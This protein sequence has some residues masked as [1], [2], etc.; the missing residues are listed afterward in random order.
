MNDEHRPPDFEGL[1]PPLEATV[2]AALAGPIPEDAIERVKARARQLAATAISPSRTSGSYHRG[3]KASRSIIAGLTAVAALLAVVI[4]VYSLLNHSG[5]R[6]FAQM[7]EKVKASSSVR[8]TTATRF[9]KQPEINGV[10]YLEGNRM[11]MEQFDGTLI[12][13]AD[14]DR[15]LGL[16]LDMHGKTVQLIEIDADAARRFANPIDQLRR[17]KSDD[18]EQIGE[19][20]LKG[21]RTR[22]YRLRKADLFGITGAEMLVWVDVESGLPA[23]IV[24]RDSDPKAGMEFRFD[25]F[26]WNE[27]LN[28][29][30]FS[31]GMP[32]GF[33]TGVV[34]STPRPKK[35]TQANATPPNNPNYLADGVLSRDHVPARIVWNPRGTTITALTQDPESV[36]PQERRPHELRQ[37]DV[38]TG[39]LR[40]SETVLGAGW[41]AGTADGKTL[42]TVIGYEVQ[43]RDAA[44]GKIT[45]KWATDERLSPLAFSPDGKTLAAGITEWGRYGGRG[46]K[47][48]GGV[49]F[50]DVERACLVRSISDDKPV[51]FVRYSVDGKYLAT[52]SNEGPEKS[53]DVAT[54]KLTRIFPGRHRADFS[55]DGET[56]ACQSAASSADKTIGKVDLY[57][58]RDGSLVKS[59][60]SEKG[61][62][63]SWLLCVTFSPDGHLL[64]ASDWN[65]TVTL[66]DV[67][68][69][70]C[71]QTITDHQAGVLAVVFAPDGAAL[72]TGSEDNTLR[73]RKLPAELRPN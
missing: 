39:K 47:E 60:A 10:M 61:A 16:L 17:A 57:K 30:L 31:L 67:A 25:E 2:K 63:A 43:L 41:L 73:L 14:F 19:E 11:R 37:W 66:W 42:A 45:R 65:G 38:A 24:I 28:A 32:D 6:A 51:T 29:Q 44:S 1:E 35:A 49:Q 4:G 13:V 56:I 8:F 27:P 70:E 20:I 59:F 22:V 18:A 58:L 50:W 23:K 3:W 62:S 55:P 69:G 72:A 33:H 9:G 64:A 5:G 21:R 12:D 53:W 46:G 15:R 36:P 52:S 40:W 68:T 71:K 34:V 26:V 7:I 54:G 48:S